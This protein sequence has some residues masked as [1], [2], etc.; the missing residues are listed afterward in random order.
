MKRPLFLAFLFLAA[1]VALA[2]ESPEKT[3]ELEKKLSELQARLDALAATANADIRAQLEEIRRQVDALTKEIETLKSG[4]PERAPEAG[5]T[6]A[7]GVGPAASKVYAVNHGVSIGGYGEFLYEN[8]DSRRQNGSPSGQTNRIDL[9]RAILYFGYKFDDHFLLNSE[10]EVEHAVTASDKRGETAIEFAYLDWRHSRA[11]NLRG[12]LVL[13]PMGF[14]NELHE[15][16]VFLAARRPEV[17]QLII[18]STWR[19]LGLGFYGD[20]GTVSYRAYLVNGLTASRYA[21][22]GIAEG[23]QEG[24]Q[25]VARDFAVT[26]RL[27]FTP[28]PG[29]LLGASVFTGNSAQGKTT[30][31]GKSFGGRTTLL[32]LHAEWR[33]RGIRVR[34]LFV[35]TR[36]SD[37][38]EINALNGLTGNQSVG[39][40]QRG[41]YLEGGYDLFSWRPAR[42][43]WRRCSAMTSI[44]R[45]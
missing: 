41:W 40:R 17:E 30:P 44:G 27:D 18:P 36:I 4:V 37:A 9:L 12:G 6:G 39:S 28:L 29:A 22:E 10:L 42:V 11:A 45:R 23:K 2:Q 8:F 34:G 3:R 43:T 1:S 25:A 35:E 14:I 7:F 33:W 31:S 38:G 15:P 24:S 32:D 13:I 16:P 26:G 19:E 20:T 21:P 5:Q